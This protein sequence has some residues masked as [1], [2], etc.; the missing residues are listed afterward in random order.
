VR[1]LLSGTTRFNEIRRYLPKLS[2]TLLNAR[3]RMLEDQG[4]V[5]KRR[6][7]EQRGFEYRLTPSGRE[8]LPIVLS[9]GRWAARWVYT[10]LNDQEINTDVLMRDIRISV[11]TSRLPEGRSVILFQLPD[12]PTMNKWYLV[13][14]NGAT[15]LCDEDRSLDVDVYVTAAR[16]T[17]AEIWTRKLDIEEALADGRLK[18]SGLAPLVKTFPQWFPRSPFAD[19]ANDAESA[20]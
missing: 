17:L 1:E 14:D 4:L 6:R 18:L 11:D 5:I 13:A 20:G 12:Q 15:E 7:P 16:I 3:L 2:P 19:A 9:I 8:L 10:G